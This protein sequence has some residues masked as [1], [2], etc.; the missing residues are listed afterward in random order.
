M[1]PQTVE[2]VEEIPLGE[3]VSG[4]FGPQAAV[5]AGSVWVSSSYVSY[6]SERSPRTPCDVVL[7]VD[8]QTKRV[9][10]QYSRGSPH[11]PGFRAWFGVGN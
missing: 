4:G 5:G 3:C 10:D 11:R 7:K 1:D 8:P 6:G 2:V 9:V